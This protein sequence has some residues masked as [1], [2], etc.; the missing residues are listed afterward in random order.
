MPSSI[1]PVDVLRWIALTW[2]RLTLTKI[3]HQPTLL[4]NLQDDY[5]RWFLMKRFL[6]VILP[7]SFLVFH[8]YARADT[9]SYEGLP[10]TN[11]ELAGQEQGCEGFGPLGFDVCWG[12]SPVSASV[13]LSQ[14]L[15]ANFVENFSIENSYGSTPSEP[16]IYVDP[17]SIAPLSFQA[18]G[19]FSDG[20]SYLGAD[21][22]ATTAGYLENGPGFLSCS[23]SLATNSTG[24]ITSWD[25]DIG[26]D[27]IE[28]IQYPGDSWSVR[29]GMSGDSVGAGSVVS[30]ETPGKW[31]GPGQ[32]PEPS[33][34]FLFGTG[35]LV[36]L[37][38][39]HRRLPHARGNRL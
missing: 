15:P 7:L 16:A 8:S 5:G 2:N 29:S 21:C 37:G 30:N 18:W 35:L 14:P 33:S 38:A 34:F 4:A 10:F 17:G 9:Y 26:W 1:T 6:L 28:P 19:G 22:F 32:T 36:V 27:A 11:F 13:T 12:A 23:L 25:M 20:F 24:K 31:A 3:A 39:I